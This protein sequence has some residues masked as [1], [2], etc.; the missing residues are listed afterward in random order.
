MGVYPCYFLQVLTP[1]LPQGRLCIYELMA[2]DAMVNYWEV[3]H[4]I[5]FFSHGFQRGWLC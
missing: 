1:Y 4:N 2:E 3:T 5:G